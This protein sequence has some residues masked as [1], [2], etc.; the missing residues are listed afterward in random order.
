VLGL[1]PP[2]YISQIIK[3]VLKG[4]VKKIRGKI[5]NI[6]AGDLRKISLKI[7]EQEM[8]KNFRIFSNNFD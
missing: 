2:T 3:K 8:K 6:L 4:Y 1:A 5:R 7:F